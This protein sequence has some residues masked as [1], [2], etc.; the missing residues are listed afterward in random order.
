[1]L[2]A[3]FKIVFEE[4]VQSIEILEPPRKQSV[5]KG[6]SPPHFVT[7]RFATYVSGILV[8][9]EEKQ[10]AILNE[11]IRQLRS[12]F[13]RLL[14][15]FADKIEEEKSRIVFLITNYSVVVSAMNTQA[16]DKSKMCKE[17]SDN[18][19]RM[20]DE[21]IEMELKEHFTRWI[22]F[23]ST[24]E[25]KLHSEPKT[26]V[27]MSQILSIVKNF[28]ET[29]QRALNNAVRNVQEN[30]TPNIAASLAQE[31]GNEELFKISKDVLKRMLSQVLLYHSRFSKLV[32]RLMS[33]QGR[34][35]EVL[36]YMVPEHVIRGEMKA[37]WNKDGK[38]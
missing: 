2:W 17:F 7:V 5:S 13:E 35:S 27:D 14:S 28:N 26:K 16:L 30:F 6:S 23:M 8:L 20:E 38:D 34:D 15:R 12:A 18:L 1:N 19:A 21:Y 31:V 29:W 33:N 25:T 22:G 4:N 9:N 37:Y 24:T 36:K 32:E 3:R 11:C 10:H